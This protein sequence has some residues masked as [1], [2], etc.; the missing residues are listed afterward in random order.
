MGLLRWE[1]PRHD[2]RFLPPKV[3]GGSGRGGGFEAREPHGQPACPPPT[4]PTQNALSQVPQPR[5]RVCLLFVPVEGTAGHARVS[6]EGGERGGGGGAG[7]GFTSLPTCPP[8]PQNIVG[9]SLAVTSVGGSSTCKSTVVDGHQAIATLITTAEGRASLVSTF[10]FCSADA[11]AT[12]AT[13]GEWAGSGVIEVPSQ[14]NDPACQTMWGEAPGCDIGSICDIMDATSGDDVAKLAAVSA[15]QHKGNCI[16]GWTEQ[17]IA[18]AERALQAAVDA[19]G[20]ELN[21]GSDALSWPYQT[22]T[23]WGFYQTCEIGSDC[24]FVQG[25][26]NL[27][28]QVGGAFVNEAVSP[29]PPCLKL[30]A[31]CPRSCGMVTI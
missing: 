9:E 7:G 8:L 20:S 5:P 29:P 1:L 13:A 3:R 24:P 10:N 17:S 31:C 11:L 22:C 14:E 28:Q 4:T 25:Y 21:G 26:N 2:E 6:G 18:N 19:L 23:E 12:E 15:A 16:G 30:T 27:S